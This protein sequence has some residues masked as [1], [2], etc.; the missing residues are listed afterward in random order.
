MSHSSLLKIHVIF[1]YRYPHHTLNVSSI[2]FNSLCLPLT[3]PAQMVPCGTCGVGNVAQG[4]V[5]SLSTSVFQCLYHAINTP[6][7]HFIRLL[8]QLL[9]HNTALLN[10]KPDSLIQS[11]YMTP[12][13]VTKP[14]KLFLCLS[15]M[16]QSIDLGKAGWIHDTATLLY[17]S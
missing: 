15:T 6:H 1:A 4:Q 17:Y 13:C 9:V 5:F 8:P 12:K 14:T 11:I 3:D 10:K 2:S 16:P 7:S